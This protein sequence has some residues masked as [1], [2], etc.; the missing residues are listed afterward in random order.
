MAYGTGLHGGNLNN[1]FT[2]LIFQRKMSL[3][4]F[5]GEQTDVKN[6][7]PF[8]AEA[9]W[10]VCEETKDALEVCADPKVGTTPP[11]TGEWLKEK[12]FTKEG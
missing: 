11:L 5:V 1:T 7:L 8:E 12:G 6:V 9:M 10:A 4:G 3:T 2:A